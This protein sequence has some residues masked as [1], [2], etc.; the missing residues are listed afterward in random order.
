MFGNEAVVASTSGRGQGVRRAAMARYARR[1]VAVS[2]VTAGLFFGFSSTGWAT[3][4]PAGPEISAPNVVAAEGHDDKQQIQVGDTKPGGASRTGSTTGRD[5]GKPTEASDPSGLMG[6]ATSAT[7]TALASLGGTPSDSAATSERTGAGSQASTGSRN[8]ASSEEPSTEGRS[9]E[10]GPSTSQAPADPAVGAD[11]SGPVEQ[12]S[13]QSSKQ[14]SEQSS[15][16]AEVFAAPT[17]DA[18]AEPTKTHSSP[19]AGDA[20]DEQQ[21]VQAVGPAAEPAATPGSSEEAPV[22]TLDPVVSDA[23]APVAQ[24]VRT[25]P[26]AVDETVDTTLADVGESAA[27][28]DQATGGGVTGLLALT[29]PVVGSATGELADVTSPVADTVDTAGSRVQSVVSSTAEV[30]GGVGQEA[31]PGDSG[32]PVAG[33]PGTAGGPAILPADGANPAETSGDSFPVL[34]GGLAFP[35]LPRGSDDVFTL[36]DTIQTSAEETPDGASH[37]GGLDQSVPTD[38]PRP[39][40]PEGNGPGPVVGGAAQIAST[41]VDVRLPDA[42]HAAAVPADAWRLPGSVTFEPGHSPD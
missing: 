27:P 18:A 38:E 7:R 11:E 34:L 15:E 10:A 33:L 16:Q 19:T 13:K 26:T 12:S 24:A 22:P 39:M 28:I 17:A 8:P 20:H 3:S 42:H 41:L 30:V 9:E 35:M 21:D 5:T 40:G 4:E 37:N 29:T 1:A 31:R 14:S 6:E 2:A 25:L 36:Q 23:T 32:D